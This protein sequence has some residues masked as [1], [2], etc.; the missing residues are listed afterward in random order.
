MIGDNITLVVTEVRG[1]KVKIGI[2]APRDISVYREE[3]Y[4][5]ITEAKELH[6]G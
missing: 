1:D 6:D 3:A 2:E 5:A 4:Q